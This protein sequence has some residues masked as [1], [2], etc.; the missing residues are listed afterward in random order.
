MNHSVINNPFH[1]LIMVVSVYVCEITH[2]SLSHSVINDRFHTLIIN[3]S[4]RENLEEA[5]AM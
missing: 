1:T 5:Q 3:L 2:K 4:L